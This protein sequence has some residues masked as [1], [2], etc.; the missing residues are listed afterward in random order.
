MKSAAPTAS[1]PCPSCE[2]D[3]FDCECEFLAPDEFY[4][5]EL[6]QDAADVGGF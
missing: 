6:E 1:R 2:L 4:P 3:E 5:G